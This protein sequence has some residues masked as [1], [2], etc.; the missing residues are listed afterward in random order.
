VRQHEQ[1][2]ESHDQQIA[3]VLT[4]VDEPRRPA[5]VPH[6][7]AT[8]EADE[9]EKQE[10]QHC[11]HDAPR[12]PPAAASSAA[13]LLLDPRSRHRGL[14]SHDGRAACH[15]RRLNGT[16]SPRECDTRAVQRWVSYESAMEDLESRDAAE[17]LPTLLVEYRSGGLSLSIDDLRKLFIYA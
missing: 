6:R 16:P 13:Q 7:I 15:A 2:R 3:D 10:R 14:H 4:A 17:R 8:A 5:D 9:R 12:A 1:E 11:E